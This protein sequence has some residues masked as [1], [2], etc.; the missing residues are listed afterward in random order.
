MTHHH[1]WRRLRELAHITLRWHVGGPLGWTDFATN[2][3]SIREG[4]TQAQRRSTVCHETIHVE[5]GPCLAGYDQ[6][7]ER[8]VNE[9]AA[10]RLIPLPTL[11]DVMLWTLDEYEMAEDL[12]TDVETVRTRLATLSVAERKMIQ[13]ELDHRTESFP[14]A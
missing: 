14:D 10:R 3:V 7:E 11:I 12:W 13:A 5:R 4:L 6:H 9:L 1:P 8:V 2:E